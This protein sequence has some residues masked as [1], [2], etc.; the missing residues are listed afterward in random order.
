MARTDI[1]PVQFKGVAPRVSANRGYPVKILH[2]RNLSTNRRRQEPWSDLAEAKRSW[3]EIFLASVP[4]AVAI[5]N[6]G[7]G[8][9]S[10]F[11]AALCVVTYA[12]VRYGTVI[13]LSLVDWLA[14]KTSALLLA[15]PLWAF[16]PDVTSSASRGAAVSIAYLV[17]LRLILRTAASLK[18]FIRLIALMTLVYSIYFLFNAKTHDLQTV[19]LSVDFA[20]GNYTG[21]VI[22]FGLTI[23]LWEAFESTNGLAWRFA[24]LASCAIDGWALFET[25]SRASAAG[26]VIA[27][28]ILIAFRTQWRAVRYTTFAILMAGFFM[29]FFPQSA[30]LFK[31]ASDP[32][33]DFET[34]NRGDVTTLN[35]AGRE[36]IWSS[37][38]EMVTDS[39]LLGYGPEGYRFRGITQTLAHAWGLEYMAS[40][41]LIGTAAILMIIWVCFAGGTV[42]SVVAPGRRAWLWNSLAAIALLPNLLLST[43]QWTLWAWAGFA[44]WSRSWL[45][46]SD[47]HKDRP[48]IES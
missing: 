11:Y 6:P 18:L 35:L 23:A 19:R 41:G 27:L 48:P 5:V 25:G 20:N 32:V 43:Q 39:W 8:Y 37:T 31:T 47:D 33:S 13:R 3:I 15:S 40:V 12:L 42:R 24:F 38:R 16:A 22:A 10:G 7:T 44:L 21:A 36:Q 29:G 46:N 17:A 26:P 34:F 4:L 14:L 1:F 30:G 28:I 2:L 45:L 9:F